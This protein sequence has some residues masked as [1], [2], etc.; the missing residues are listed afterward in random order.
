MA[1]VPRMCQGSIEGIKVLVKL[2]HKAVSLD[3]VE[4]QQYTR[5]ASKRATEERVKP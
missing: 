3:L 1:S 2:L 5:S 4:H